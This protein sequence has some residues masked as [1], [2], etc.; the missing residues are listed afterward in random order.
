MDKRLKLLQAALE[1]EI[2]CR[3]AEQSGKSESEIV[4]LRYEA[5]E[6]KDATLWPSYISETDVADL[7]SKTKRFR[8][9][10]DD[11]LPYMDYVIEYSTK[12]SPVIRL[13]MLMADDTV[14][15]YRK[16][17]EERRSLMTDIEKN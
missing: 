11:L 9:L 2:E 4:R 10:D 16:R 8:E 15:P 17:Q 5:S 13:V 14:Q 7:A 1:A 3:A 12:V 6:L